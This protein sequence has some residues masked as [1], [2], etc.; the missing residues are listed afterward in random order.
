[1]VM[2]IVGCHSETQYIHEHAHVA[3]AYE[4]LIGRPGFPIAC[5][6]VNIMMQLQEP[7]QHLVDCPT[8]R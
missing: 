8:S 7:S 3:T 4:V 5:R 1:M 6:Q 2:L